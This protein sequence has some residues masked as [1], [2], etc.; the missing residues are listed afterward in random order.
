MRE[1]VGGGM[2]MYALI[3]FFIGIIIFIASVMQYTDAYRIVNKCITEI[4]AS[5]NCFTSCADVEVE[6]MSSGNN[7]VAHVKKS[8]DFEFPFFG[9]VSVFNV[10]ADSKTIH[11][12]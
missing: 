6:V 3:P 7:C 11:N 8:V 4:E 2:L 10:T 1:A 9:K 12:K 5:E